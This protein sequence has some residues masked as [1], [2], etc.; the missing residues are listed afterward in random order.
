MGKAYSHSAI[1]KAKAE[2]LTELLEEQ[3]KQPNIVSLLGYLK[4]LKDTL[5]EMSSDWRLPE[6]LYNIIAK[7]LNKKRTE[8]V[9]EAV[10]VLEE[11]VGSMR[12]EF[13][14]W[15]EDKDE[16]RQFSI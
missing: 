4:R 6:E 13:D 10:K 5:E 15:W 14:V 16:P 7:K 2:E 9:I 11:W 3:K 12:D 1:L 8:K